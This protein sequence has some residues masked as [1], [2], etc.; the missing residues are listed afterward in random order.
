MI[1]LNDNIE[2]RAPKG[3]DTRHIKLNET[4]MFSIPTSYRKEGISIFRLD[5]MT[6][7]QL[8]GGIVNSNWIEYMNVLI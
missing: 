6:R 2:V 4:D 1:I 3:I 5:T 7:F 8:R